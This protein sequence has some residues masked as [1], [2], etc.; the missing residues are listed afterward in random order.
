MAKSDLRLNFKMTEY[1]YLGDSD[2]TLYLGEKKV[3]PLDDDD[4]NYFKITTL[5]GNAT[6]QW[7]GSTTANTMSYSNDNGQTWSTPR[8]TIKLSGLPINK[9]ILF[10]RGNAEQ[11]ISNNYGIGIFICQSAVDVSGNIMSLVYAEDEFEEQ[12]SLSGKN[13]VF[14]SLFT[15]A[16]VINANNLLLPATTLSSGCYK[17]MFS[18]CT[19]LVSPPELPATALTSTCYS[20]MFKGCTNLVTPPELPATELASGCYSFMFNGCNKLS[21]S[22]E[23]PSLNVPAT[24]YESM[25][26]GCTNL[27][28]ARPI[29]A[30]TIGS[31][32]CKS[33]FAFCSSLATPPEMHITTVGEYSLASA[34]TYCYTLT[35]APDLPAETLK[36]YCY[37]NMFRYCNELSKASISATTLATGC[38]SGMFVEVHKLTEIELLAK[39]PA[40]QCYEYM[41]DQC[42]ELS[43]V[44]CHLTSGTSNTAYFT[45]WMNNVASVGTFYKDKNVTWGIRTASGV[46]SNWTIV[47][48]E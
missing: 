2:I 21:A 15:Q 14:A 41:F 8:R 34:F 37:K 42:T 28:L 20:Y 25:F 40:Q 47:N 39:T 43:T 1:A 17:Q 29:S 12:T 32:S 35:E 24:A 33:I 22:T 7:S 11:S 44:K 31:N 3:Y 45:N 19:N 16:A 18:G 46:P 48:L 10:K 6:I 13:N 5:I 30:T 4:K 36:N 9:T 26:S 23:L 27:T 38:C